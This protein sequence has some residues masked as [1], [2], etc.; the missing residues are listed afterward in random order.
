MD[1]RE[2]LKVWPDWQRAG[3]ETVL[4]SPAWRM[5]VR[6]NGTEGTMV[7]TTPP[8]DFLVLDVTLDGEAHRLALTDTSAYPDLHLLWKRRGELPEPLLLA[9]V[10]KECG[11]VFSLVESVTRRILAVKG[12]SSA[13]EGLRYFSVSAAGIDIAFGL[14]VTPDLAATLGRLDYI[15]PAH[16][17]VR[18]S[19]RPARA[20]LGSLSLTEEELAT[21]TPGVS[22]LLP[23]GFGEGA[24]WVP[25][26]EMEASEGLPL[27]APGEVELSFA[28][29]AD[30][31]FPPIPDGTTFELMRGGRVLCRCA[32]ARVGQVR[33]LKVTETD[34]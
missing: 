18:A 32:D 3:T 31:S 2:L 7:A 23:E 34:M 22:L 12:L 4:A 30:E 25:A 17:A 21:L 26:D 33:A 15:D 5:P 10:E 8:A 14:D 13:D 9:L 1:A 19:M 27:V 29:F 24:R 6:M 28:T 20:V 11:G 16:P